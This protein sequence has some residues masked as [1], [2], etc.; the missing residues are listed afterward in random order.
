MNALRNHVL[1][2]MAQLDIKS[3]LALQSIVAALKKPILPSYQRGIGAA[4]C[5][6]ALAGLQ[7]CLSQTIIEER[8]D[9]L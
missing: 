6:K 9:R 8:D 5:R 1:H 4:K 3:L 7:N 2:E